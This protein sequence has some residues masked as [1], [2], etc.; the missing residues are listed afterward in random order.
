MFQ[1]VSLVLGLCVA[2]SG[3]G[4][5]LCRATGL[6][7]CLGGISTVE[8]GRDGLLSQSPHQ[9]GAVNGLAVGDVRS[10]V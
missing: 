10:E 1:C 6:L 7:S 5:A 8:W 9:H 2:L 3:D 4:P